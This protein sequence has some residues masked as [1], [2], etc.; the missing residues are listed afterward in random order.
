MKE[1]LEIARVAAAAGGA[2]LAQRRDH[3]GAIRSKGSR[4]DL[5]T[6]TDIASGVATVRSILAADPSA[7][8]IV[9][10]PEV[11]DLLGIAPGSLDDEEVWLVDPLDGTTSY[12]HG[13]PCYSVAVACVR[14]GI[15]VVGA[16]MNGATG[17]LIS[18]AEGHGAHCGESPIGC[19]AAEKVTDALVITGFPY[20]R[21]APL[22]RQL[23]VLSAFL[24]APIHGM[25]RDGSAA[26]DCTH[27]ATGRA[28]GFW[29]YALKP[30]DMAAGAV[31][32]REAGAVVTDV[33]GR[34]WDCGCSSILTANPALHAE[35]LAL[36]GSSGGWD[37]PIADQ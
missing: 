20:D 16:I 34:P 24:R 23:A 32:C 14:R 19:S 9:E 37:D 28:D 3:V 6:E 10:E 29:E 13:Y 12:I 11:Y 17:E 15:P 18:A 4:I 25:R 5:V 31:I 36:I 2:V 27:V 8:V 26:V 21:G 7:S 1:R 30:W 33:N 22:D 35:M